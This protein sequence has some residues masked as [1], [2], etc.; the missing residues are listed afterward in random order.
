LVLF[1]VFPF[2]SPLSSWLSFVIIISLS[3]M[4]HWASQHL[5]FVFLLLVWSCDRNSVLWLMYCTSLHNP[6]PGT[7]E[8]SGNALVANQHLKCHQTGV[9]VT[10]ILTLP[11]FFPFFRAWSPLFPVHWFVVR[12]EIFVVLLLCDISVLFLT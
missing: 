2:C 7:N 1:G 3:F 10:V 11:N 12:I 4:L 8:V 9:C 6:L 5:D